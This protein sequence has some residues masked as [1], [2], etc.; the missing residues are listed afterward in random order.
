MVTSSRIDES[1][2]RDMANWVELASGVVFLVLGVL[3]IVY[4]SRLARLN[5]DTLRSFWGPRGEGTARRSTALQAGLTGGFFILLALLA[6][7]Q[8]LFS[9]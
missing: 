5:A 4:R 9:R 7:L 8:S 2:T 1:G 6:I 3:I